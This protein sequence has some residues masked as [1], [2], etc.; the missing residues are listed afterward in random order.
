MPTTWSRI[1][2]WFATN[3]PDFADDLLAGA[4]DTDFKAAEQAMGV[5]LPDELKAIY[6][7]HNGQDG[8]APGI[9]GNWEFLPLKSAVKQWQ[10]MKGLTD[11]GTF[12]KNTVR[13]KGLV[14]AT[15]WNLK[16][17]PFA[18]NGSGNLLVVDLDPPEGG[19]VGQVVSY[20]H[21][22]DD[23]ECI[24]GGIAA[25]FQ[26]LATDLEQGALEY[27]DGELVRAR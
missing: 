8:G 10:I 21:D 13:V 18:S 25:W 14:R 23:R 4:T 20:V 17:V 7:V 19:D 12:K 2:Q 3:A 15:W 9:A 22:D 16:W 26:S 5:T 6:R 24:A 1:E 27:R 11:K